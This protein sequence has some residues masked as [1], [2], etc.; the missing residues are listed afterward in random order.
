[1]A[2]KYADRWLLRVH[3]RGLGQR[4]LQAHERPQTVLPFP[5]RR[6]LSVQSRRRRPPPPLADQLADLETP[7]QP[8]ELMGLS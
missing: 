1:M 8:P 5:V 4:E 6:L 3:R 7:V 2:R